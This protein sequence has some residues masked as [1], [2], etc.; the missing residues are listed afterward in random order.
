LAAR[1]P[2]LL[3]R[4]LFMLAGSLTLTGLALV[5]L[6]PARRLDAQVQALM[7]RTGGG[8]ALVGLSAQVGAAVALVRA[9]PAEV[10][11]RLGASSFYHAAALVWLGLAGLAAFVAVGAIAR[12]ARPRAGLA[13]TAALTGFSLTLVAAIYRDGL[14]DLTLLARG[15]DVWNRQ[16]VVNLPIVGLFLGLLVVGL[17]LLG[18]MTWVAC[19]TRPEEVT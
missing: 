5:A 16:V 18:W 9:Q 11:E 17:L 19:M 13:W 10:A 14:R 4:W 3:P 15:F 2:T 6:A 7:V 8:A 12:A 1:D